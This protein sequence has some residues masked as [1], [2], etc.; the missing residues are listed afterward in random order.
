MFSRKSPAYTSSLRNFSPQKTCFPSR[1]TCFPSKKTCFFGVYICDLIHKF[2][3]HNP[4]HEIS[5]SKKTYFLAKKHAFLQKNMFSQ[6]QKTCFLWQWNKFSSTPQK[7]CFCS[8]KTCFRSRKTCFCGWKTCFPAHPGKT[9]FCSKNMLFAGGKHDSMV[10]MHAFL[11][12]SNIMVLSSRKY[13]SSGKKNMF[14]M[15]S[16]KTHFWLG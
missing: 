12:N 9:W 15:T 7:T 8:K 14:S 1:K 10:K 16:K 2:I 3:L 4:T 11:K 6:I 5:P 13:V